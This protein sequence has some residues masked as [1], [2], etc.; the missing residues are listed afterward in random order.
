MVPFTLASDRCELH[1]TQAFAMPCTI[2]DT[3][4]R[5][6]NSHGLRRFTALK[7]HV[8]TGTVRVDL[9]EQECVPRGKALTV[10]TAVCRCVTESDGK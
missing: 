8:H 5:Q 1:A 10:S 3:Y 9:L 7:R 2:F 4:S 6:L